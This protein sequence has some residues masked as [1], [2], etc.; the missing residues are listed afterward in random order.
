MSRNATP[1]RDQ[2]FTAADAWHIVRRLAP[3]LRIAH[4]IA[5]RVR[6][7]LDGAA[8]NDVVI[9]AIGLKRLRDG[10]KGLRGV[11]EIEFNALARSC[12]V[13]YDNRVIP[14]AAWSDLLSGRDSAAAAALI[15]VMLERYAEIGGDA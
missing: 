13:E 11:R 5:G 14:D 2:G 3:H 4:Q 6:V 15:A 10:A 9:V 12:V 7:K 1:S 8:A